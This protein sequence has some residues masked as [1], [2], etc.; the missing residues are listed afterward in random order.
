MVSCMVKLQ[1]NFSDSC[2]NFFECQNFSGYYG[3]IGKGVVLGFFIIN[4]LNL[5]LRIGQNFHS[6]K[7]QYLDV[8]DGKY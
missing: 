4:W 5:Y 3:V 6:L 7:A 8:V 1:L 2:S